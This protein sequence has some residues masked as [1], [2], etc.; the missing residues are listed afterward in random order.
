MEDF[1]KVTMEELISYSKQKEVPT[2]TIIDDL[3]ENQFEYVIKIVDR[4]K[5]VMV[6]IKN[7]K[8]VAIISSSKIARKIAKD[9]KRKSQVMHYDF[10]KKPSGSIVI[11]ALT[12]YTKDW[13]IVSNNGYIVKAYDENGNETENW[14]NTEI[15]NVNP[16]TLNSLHLSIYSCTVCLKGKGK[17]INTEIL[18][19]SRKNFLDDGIYNV[20]RNC[21]YPK[22]TG[23]NKNI[24][25]YNKLEKLFK[26]WEFKS[27]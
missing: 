16:I 5:L 1:L 19:H 13:I 26:K 18:E 15:E 12:G 20:K 21:Y 2:V 11:Y 23:S 24:A 27:I 6:L 10:V 7:S 22:N 17:N 14:L 4:L 25:E 9:L 8:K 3:K